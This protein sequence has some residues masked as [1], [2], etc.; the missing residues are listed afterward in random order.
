MLKTGDST[1]VPCV[2]V[3]HIWSNM[4]QRHIRYLWDDFPKGHKLM[5]KT[6]FFLFPKI[7]MGDKKVKSFSENDK[8]TWKDIYRV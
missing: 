7:I 2:V 3:C 4:R 1:S 6:R 5:L 8:R